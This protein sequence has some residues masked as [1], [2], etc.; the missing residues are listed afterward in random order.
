MEIK[1]TGKELFPQPVSDLLRALSVV[2]FFE[3]SMLVGSWVMPLYAEF[4]NISYALRTMDID[5]AVQLTHKEKSAADLTEIIVSQGF[6]PFF[7]QS[8]LQKFTREGFSVEFITHRP[9][10]R[11]ANPMLSRQ[12]NITAVALPFINVLTAFP[13]ACECSGFSIR[14]PIPEAFF[15]HKLI[16]AARRREETKQSKDLEQCSAIA[17]HLNAEQLE[18]VWRSLRLSRK[19]R[20]SV[21]SSCNAIGFPPHIFSS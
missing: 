21:H 17:P 7:T 15:L 14:A 9:D 16:V 2:G 20:A 8:G 11:D 5:F 10:N 1:K 13:F 19:T 3:E 4:Y 18:I 6:A 12:W